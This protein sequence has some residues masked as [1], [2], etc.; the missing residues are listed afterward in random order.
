MKLRLR[1][2]QPVLL[3]VTIAGDRGTREVLSVLDTGADF[4]LIPT[5]DALR[6]GYDLA[7]APRL[8]ITTANG[9]IEAP[10]IILREV[11]IGS[12]RAENVEALC[13]DMP[14]AHVSAL[15]GLS[16]LRHFK[17]TLDFPALALE[18]SGPARGKD[19][20]ETP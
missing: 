12:L 9:I 20:K 5:E 4:V 8:P 13:Y 17:I 16:L 6:L 18:I 19:W 11:S 7:K 10:K 2:D 1:P 14:G 3:Y 15:L